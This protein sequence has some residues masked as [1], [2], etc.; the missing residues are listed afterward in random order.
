MGVSSYGN[1]SVQGVIP[2][3]RRGY[4]AY[5]SGRQANGQ[6]IELSDGERVRLQHVAGN[7]RSLQKHVWWDRFLEQRVDGLLRDATRPP[8]K[9]P[10][11]EER[12]RAL[13]DLG[14]STTSSVT[15]VISLI[16]RMRSIWTKRR[17]RS[18]KL[19]PVMRAIEAMA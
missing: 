10:I 9:K 12:V 7:P 19:P 6:E 4:A 13:V 1:I 2:F 5:E 16:L 14:A 11:P 3:S 18:L 8:G 15:R 17:C